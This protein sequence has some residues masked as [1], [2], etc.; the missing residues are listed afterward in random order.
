M[1]TVKLCDMHAHVLPGMD[2]GCKTAEEAVAVLKSCYDQ[3]VDRI[4]ATPHY[5]PV[6]SIEDFLKR[7]E[8]AYSA[9]KE[10]L[11]DE[12]H[13][14]QICLGAEVAYRAG[15]GYEKE[16]YRLCLGSSRYL[17]LEMPFTRWNK[18]VIRDVCNMYAAAG[19][20]PI[21]AHIERYFRLGQKEILEQVGQM[22]VLVQMNAGYLLR[23]ATRR[24]GRKLL[25]TGAAQLLGS[26]CHDPVDRAPNLGAAA[27]YLEKKRMDEALRRS[28]IVS[29]EIFREATQQ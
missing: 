17:L 9:L 21:L 27:R 19:I 6:E 25:K 26:D 24:A 15:L 5:Y 10:T 22:D 1:K 4:F 12:D 18:E 20:T 28:I 7:R 14:P 8:A 13:I 3:G 29:G 16:L 11:R 2:D 23:P